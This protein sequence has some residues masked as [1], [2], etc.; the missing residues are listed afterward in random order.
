MSTKLLPPQE[1]VALENISW[2][3]MDSA[4][5]APV[6]Y[7][8]LLPSSQEIASGNDDGR[9]QTLQRQ[10]EQLKAENDKR[11]QDALAA[12]RREGEA[13]AREALAVNVNAEI[14]RIKQL[15]KSVLAAAPLLRKQAEGDLVRLAV[16]I[17][18]RILHREL[19]VDPEALLGLTKAA[20]S[21][22]D[23]R[24]IQTIRTHPDNVA[25]LGRVLEQSRS[26]K[27]IEILGDAR[28]DR[29]ALVI[30]T[31]RGQLDASVETHLEEIERGFADLVGNRS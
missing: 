23:Q 10:L 21:K 3:S 28:L 30:E 6:S 8:A 26:Q 27:K 11:V 24:E 1:A 5:P 15:S 7:P 25:L 22:I 18:R 29:G 17:A 31:G 13:A 20:L 9:F 14:E 4:L 2:P 12:G 16:A 19:A